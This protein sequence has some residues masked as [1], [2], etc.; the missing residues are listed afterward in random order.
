M[1]ISPTFK[2]LVYKLKLNVIV[3]INFSGQL[4]AFVVQIYFVKDDLKEFINSYYFLFWFKNINIS[5]R[6]YILLCNKPVYNPSFY[7]LLIHIASE[8]MAF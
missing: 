5:E 2:L 1:V 8:Y 7:K 3:I 6:A 4:S